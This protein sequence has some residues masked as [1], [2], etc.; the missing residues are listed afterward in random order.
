MAETKIALLPDRGVVT[1]NGPDA[2][3]FLQGVIT[4]DMALIDTQQALYAGLLSPQGKILF[5]F[6]IAPTA[7]GFCL[8]TART[9]TAELAQRLKMYK[10]RADVEV[11]DASADYTVAAIWGGAYSP[12]TATG[13]GPA[14]IW[15]ADPR[16]PELGYRE[17]T[18]LRTDWALG[19]GEAESA[20]QDD[21]HA[22]R[23]ALGVPEG[24]RDFGYGEAFPH[25]ALFDQVHGVSFNKGCY[26]GQEVVSRMHNRGTAR[27]RIVPITADGPLPES[28]AAVVAA[29]VEIGKLG[30]KA[31]QRALAEIRLDRA[32]EFQDKGEALSIGGTT[33]HIALPAWA[34]F[35]LQDPSGTPR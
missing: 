7:E 10:L 25:E 14:P 30:S 8:E 9:K 19:G 6:L 29:G 31:G 32:A 3:K 13:E 17:L 20:T 24:G 16:L 35:T 11:T 34:T 23:I 21:Y 28:G 22:H 2:R 15:F 5:D 18:T 27:R 1:V 26:V 33:V 12:K 4:N